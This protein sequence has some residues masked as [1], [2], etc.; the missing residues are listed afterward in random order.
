MSSRDAVIVGPVQPFA[1][2]AHNA[3]LTNARVMKT[4]A[5]DFIT[6]RGIVLSEKKN[7]QTK[8]HLLDTTDSEAAII[9]LFIHYIITVLRDDKSPAEI[10]YKI[11]S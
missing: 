10:K 6:D 11:R 7:K 3:K 4:A 9:F 1:S 5:N 8:L 2:R